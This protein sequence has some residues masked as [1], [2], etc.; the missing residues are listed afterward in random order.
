MADGASWLQEEYVKIK[1][2][3]AIQLFWKENQGTGFDLLQQKAFKATLSGEFI[4]E[5]SGFKK[6]LASSIQDRE[7]EVT[8]AEAEYVR[9]PTA[10]GLRD[11]TR[12]YREI[13]TDQTTKLRLAQRRRIFEFG[14]K[15]SRLLAYLAKPD[16]VPTYI[17]SV[18]DQG[19]GEVSDSMDILTSLYPLL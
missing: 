15:N 4:A 11:K 2:T 1:C 12:A 14:D 17:M 16:Y 8:L 18:Y 7:Q 13:L 3:E 19:M 9:R 6:Q 10:E 5:A